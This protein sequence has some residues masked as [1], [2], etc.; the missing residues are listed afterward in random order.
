MLAELQ[1]TEAAVPA[2][3]LPIYRLEAELLKLPQVDMQIG[4]AHV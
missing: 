3:H 2:H 4:R 1:K